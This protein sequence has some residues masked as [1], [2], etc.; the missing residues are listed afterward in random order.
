[1]DQEK[2]GQF[3]AELR[4]EKNNTKTTWKKTRNY[5]SCYFKMGKWSWYARFITNETTM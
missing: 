5:W 1:M 3:I 4:K 2:I